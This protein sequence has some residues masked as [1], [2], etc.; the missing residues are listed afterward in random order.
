M[1]L[2][3]IFCF[4][5]LNEGDFYYSHSSKPQLFRVVQYGSKI[6]T[7][8]T[9]KKKAQSKISPY[10][11]VAAFHNIIGALSGHRIFE[12]LGFQL[13]IR[14]KETKMALITDYNQ[15]V[16]VPEQFD[17]VSYDTAE[18]LTGYKSS[19]ELIAILEN[20]IIKDLD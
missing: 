13:P 4:L 17:W 10:I 20:N 11:Y 5:G 14:T 2:N 19:G 6:F 15:L 8:P 1:I 18:L 12:R 9:K 3:S 16:F 7:D